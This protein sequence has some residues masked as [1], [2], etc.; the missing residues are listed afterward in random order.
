MNYKIQ[1]L[2]DRENAIKQNPDLSN[3]GREKAL[4]VLSIEKAAVFTQI[5]T[6]L[7]RQAVAAALQAKKMAG[8]SWALNQIEAEKLDYSRLNYEAQAVKSA[9][10]LAG[11]DP[12][13]ATE[14]WQRAKAQAD[15][16]K[17]RAWL[18]QAP[19]LFPENSKVDPVGWDELKGDMTNS[20]SLTHSAEMA[21]YENEKRA[22]LEELTAISSEAAEVADYCGPHNFV[23]ARVFEGIALDKTG[24]LNVNFSQRDGEDLDQTYTRL[25]AE[26]SERSKVQKEVFEAF[27]TVYDPLVDGVAELEEVAK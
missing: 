10:A 4:K 2:N 12:Q 15:P 18:D 27:G 1:E 7:R 9:L 26:Y 14:L 8:V 11:D 20:V 23:M 22:H 24:E 19:A 3:Q 5:A 6:T 25:E 13:R 21:R 17:I 16:Y